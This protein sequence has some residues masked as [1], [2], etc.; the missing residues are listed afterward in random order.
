M[1]NY[2]TCETELCET[3]PIHVVCNWIGNTTKVASKHY[4]QV[5]DDHFARAM[6]QAQ[7]ISNPDSGSI[8]AL[9]IAGID[10]IGIK[11]VE[12]NRD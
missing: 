1:L 7:T 8:I 4:L 9:F 6:Q 2:P 10:G 5:T 12:T 3:F 11:Y